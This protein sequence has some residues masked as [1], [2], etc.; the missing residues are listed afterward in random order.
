[1][2]NKSRNEKKAGETVNNLLKKL[3]DKMLNYKIIDTKG[4]V[5][6][7]IANFRIDNHRHISLVISQY[8]AKDDAPQLIL[9]SEHIEKI[10]SQSKSVFVDLVKADFEP[11]L[12]HQG[13][14]E[15]RKKVADYYLKNNQIEQKKLKSEEVA[16]VIEEEIIDL[17]EERLVVKRS[18]RKVG[19]VVVRKQIE[20]EIVEVPVRREKLIVERVGSE[21][22]ALAEIDLG[23]EEVTSLEHSQ[24]SSSQSNYFVSGEFLSPQAASQVLGAIALQNYHGCVKVRVELVLEKPELQASYQQ[25][26]DRCFSN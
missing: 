14:N 23:K 19:E 8:L 5:I 26:F 12:V 25:M 15:N 17:L 24:T 2:I 11:G 22:E 18:K 4:Q 1:M 20:T 7:E 10:D 13:I 9:S 3:R 16:E 6:G 21:S